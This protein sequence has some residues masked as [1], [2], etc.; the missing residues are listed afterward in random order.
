MVRLTGFSSSA[1]VQA[2]GQAASAN[3]SSR[4]EVV[5]GRRGCQAQTQQDRPGRSVVTVDRNSVSHPGDGSKSHYAGK[6]LAA[7]AGDE[8]QTRHR[9]AGIHA[10]QGAEL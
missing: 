5:I 6:V 9:G 10:H 1:D 7:I 2:G 8:S 3:R 4:S